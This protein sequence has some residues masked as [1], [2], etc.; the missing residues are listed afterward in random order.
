MRGSKGIPIE[1]KVYGVNSPEKPLTMPDWSTLVEIIHSSLD[2]ISDEERQETIEVFKAHFPSENSNTSTALSRAGLSS[3]AK[4]IFS[5]VG[6]IA[7]GKAKTRDMYY[8][9]H[10][11]VALAGLVAASKVSPGTLSKYANEILLEELKVGLG[12]S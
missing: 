11:E 4:R 8:N 3:K 10:C 5:I 9:M 2:G 1:I 12:V 6:D 7:T